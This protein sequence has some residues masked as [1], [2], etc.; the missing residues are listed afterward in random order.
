VEL[1]GSVEARGAAVGETPLI[2]RGEHLSVDMQQQ[3]VHSDSRVAIDWGRMR[4]TAQRLHINVKDGTLRLE[5][6]GHGELAP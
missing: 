1:S 4:L 3:T 6:G 5:S 2:V